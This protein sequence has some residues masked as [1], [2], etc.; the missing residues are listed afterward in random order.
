MDAKLLVS[1]YSSLVKS[2]IER[3]NEEILCQLHNLK[4]LFEQIEENDET[5]EI[6]YYPELITL[7]IQFGKENLSFLVDGTFFDV[8]LSLAKKP[9][10]LLEMVKCQTFEF[11]QESII[12]Y[13][14]SSDLLVQIFSI[15]FELS[16]TDNNNEELIFSL[17]EQIEYNFPSICSLIYKTLELRNNYSHHFDLIEITNSL[18]GNFAEYPQ[19]RQ[20]LIDSNGLLDLY[21][22]LL[23]NRAN[24]MS[25]NLYL[26]SS[27]IHGSSDII[28]TIIELGLI[29]PLFTALLTHIH[30]PLT[31]E[32]GVLTL[33]YISNDIDDINK[34]FIREDIL[35][36]LFDILQKY[37]EEVSIVIPFSNL[38]AN[39]SK[40]TI[41]ENEYFTVN[42]IVKHAEQI[43]TS[44]Q[45]H[46]EIIE[47]QISIISNLP[48]NFKY[49][50]INCI[51][52]SI[53][54]SKGLMNSIFSSIEKYP[55]SHVIN[56][57]AF[58]FFQYL[59]ENDP[60][61]LYLF[62]SPNIRNII[63]HQFDIYCKRDDSPLILGAIVT[64]LAQLSYENIDNQ[65]LIGK[66]RI[67]SFCSVI[68]SNFGSEKIV[69]DICFL[70]CNLSEI[71]EFQSEIGHLGGIKVI[72]D[73][74]ESFSNNP[75]ILLHSTSALGNLFH[76]HEANQ[77][78]FFQILEENNLNTEPKFISVL[79]NNLD[80]EPI[81][82]S[83]CAMFYMLVVDEHR[84]SFL[85]NYESFFQKVV[86][87]YPGNE[88]IQ[89]FTSQILDNTLRENI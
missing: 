41:P 65:I 59:L 68:I 44:Y 55:Y 54:S 89:F 67:G 17:K 8:L 34:I 47:G 53:K 51:L 82:E 26:L 72:L 86:D 75:D 46:L 70:L 62:G 40:T 88:N 49:E 37:P 30:D 36:I 10:N 61:N 56:Q 5:E 12:F 80:S 11:L 1:S 4:E 69:K 25:S 2:L 87:I 74:I 83:I 71:Q 43:L 13:E 42:N 76:H 84:S 15:L 35:Q 23:N 6:F 81:I 66:E 7:L 16:L 58:P 85:N 50:D 29:D 3:E 27:L 21:E 78:I 63:L 39:I 28:Q 20:L 32:N 38:L 31:V 60:E 57:N 19:V 77:Q 18:L 45:T 79:E 52:N 14:D 64:L 73:V 24:T 33:S 9:S 22:L 48:I